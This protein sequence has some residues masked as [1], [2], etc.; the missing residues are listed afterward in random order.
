[1]AA[2][3][4]PDREA[5]PGAR[6]GRPPAPEQP[7]PEETQQEELPPEPQE[8]GENEEDEGEPKPPDL[9]AL[10][11]KADPA[12]LRKHPRLAGIIGEQAKREATRLAEQRADELVR[13]REER[14]RAE[15]SR[16][17]VL[18]KAR[19]G[20]Y[21]AIGEQAAKQA[22]Q[23]DQEGAVNQ[24]TRRAEAQTYQKVQATLEEWATEQPAEVNEA[25]AERMGA[26]DAGTPWEQ[27]FRKWLDAYVQVRA[28][29][30]MRNPD[31]QKRAERD[32]TPAVRARVLAEMN[33]K[34]PTADSGSGRPQRV[35]TITDDDISRMELDEYMSVW[36]V[37]KGRPKK[38]VVY[39][40]TR[41]V[42]PR[43]MQVRGGP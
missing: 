6:P 2:T 1:M 10:L 16:Q 29:H 7:D 23:Q 9:N 27:G 37:E 40:P 25:A 3:E 21:Y 19:N 12:T 14:W 43:V 33:G 22:L 39:K 41:A 13:E 28:E 30:L 24:F 5:A 42:D 15:R 26:L 31:T 17:E 35:R 34:E 36:D 32:V 20:D 4:A 8:D 38:G 11:D 18:A